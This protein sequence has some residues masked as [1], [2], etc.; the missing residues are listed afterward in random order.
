LNSFLR[1]ISTARG[2]SI[3]FNSNDQTISDKNSVVIG[4]DGGSKF[5]KGKA[6]DDRMKEILALKGE[7]IS[8]LFL[9][10]ADIVFIEVFQSQICIGFFVRD[11][12]KAL[13]IC[14]SREGE[15]VPEVPPE[16]D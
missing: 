10:T 13:A 9:K 16:R 8:F 5:D 4:Y 14:S 1:S 7:M 3:H 12:N 15:S 11:I 6:G 2:V